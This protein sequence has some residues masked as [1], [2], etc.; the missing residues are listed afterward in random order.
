[1]EIPSDPPLRALEV[2]F[3]DEAITDPE[4]PEAPRPPRRAG[5]SR[6]FA[7]CADGLLL[8]LLLGAHAAIALRANPYLLDA[9]LRE[10]RLFALLAALLSVAYSWVLIALLGRTPGM[11]LFGQRLQT[12]DGRPPTPAQALW[13]ALLS[14]LSA[15][16]L[17]GFVLALFDHRG[18]TLHDK[19]CGCVVRID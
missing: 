7:F 13:R 3:E 1:M 19:L 18:Q 11:A 16:G 6:A 4:K 12:L 15:I 14:L 10:W 5:V 2:S 8:A 9:L 17:F